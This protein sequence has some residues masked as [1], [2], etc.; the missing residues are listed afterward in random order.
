MPAGKVNYLIVYEHDPQVYGCASKDIALS[1]P[2]PEGFTLADKRVYYVTV[3]PDN[4]MLVWR[5]LP[6]EEVEAAEL[7]AH[8]K[9]EKNEQE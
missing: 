7:K 8:K 4:K 2:P 1:T 3:E 5:R 9:K 6:Q